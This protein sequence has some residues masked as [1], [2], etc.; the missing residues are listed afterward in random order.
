M[1]RFLLAAIALVFM[2][3]F[4][5][6]AGWV[7][8]VL[9]EARPAQPPEPP[10][11]R[12]P[13]KNTGGEPSEENLRVKWN[14]AIRPIAVLGVLVAPLLAVVLAVN[15]YLL[16]LTLEQVFDQVG[17]PL[18]TITLLSRSYAATVFD[19]WGAL[20]SLG[21]VIA[22]SVSAYGFLSEPRPG[23]KRP[24]VPRWVRVLA[25]S[26]VLVLA[27]SEISTSAYRSFLVNNQNFAA[28]VLGAGMALG[29]VLLEALAGLVVLEALLL[30]LLHAILA[31]ISALLGWGLGGISGTVRVMGCGRGRWRGVLAAFHSVFIE[32]LRK[33][34][35]ALCD[36]LIKTLENL[37]PAVKLVL[38]AGGIAV[39]LL[40]TGCNTV[41]PGPP[42]QAVTFYLGYDLTTS[43]PE[44]EF[45]EYREMAVRFVLAH[46]ENGDGVFLIPIVKDPQGAVIYQAFDRARIT[47][48]ARTFF[49][50]HISTLT[51]PTE[52]PQKP[53]FTDLG[54]VISF[55]IRTATGRAGAG[56]PVTVIFTDGAP[57]GPQTVN[58][59]DPPVDL[60][61]W[62]V[63]VHPEN[64]KPL[65]ELCRRAHVP[66]SAIK[67]VYFGGWTAYPNDFGGELQRA[68][69]SRVISVCLRKGEK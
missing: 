3:L 33:I 52:G 63:G 10:P 67:V 44:Q 39:I 58:A 13:S 30:P 27:A 53:A 15:I 54:A 22:A 4:I 23:S 64:E 26:S 68:M 20:I 1:T 18:L 43:V 69:N 40:L 31:T 42:R 50:Q 65:R 49:A 57:S 12:R 16:R 45:A 24:E 48:T 11:D 36:S 55:V 9:S 47:D 32:P 46:V 62:F 5:L 6:F 17:E 66:E 25:T 7:D 60:R 38:V 34:D 28:G 59:G 35:K 21:Q 2:V 37:K 8:Q 56:R 29:V 61:I 19:A 41:R 14:R 51:Q